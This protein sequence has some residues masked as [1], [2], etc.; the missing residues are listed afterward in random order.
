MIKI[1]QQ[2]F[3]YQNVFFIKSFFLSNVR[4]NTYSFGNCTIV[5]KENI[6][7]RK[8]IVLLYYS[9]CLSYIFIQ[10]NKRLR[11][12][13]FSTLW[14]WEG[15]RLHFDLPWLCHSQSAHNVEG[16]SK[17]LKHVRIQILSQIVEILIVHSIQ[18]FILI[19]K[20]LIFLKSDQ[21]WHLIECFLMELFFWRRNSFFLSWNVKRMWELFKVHLDLSLTMWAHCDW[22]CRRNVKRMWA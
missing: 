5:N 4:R 7:E 17:N 19:S 20:I 21:N 2:W 22:Q 12:N 1:N 8:M 6:S 16:K 14:L 9:A 13:L 18:F 11:L 15:F 3:Y 10:L